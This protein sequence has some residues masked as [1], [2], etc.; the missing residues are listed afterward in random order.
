MRAST[1][2]KRSR[3]SHNLA[4]RLHSH[5]SQAITDLYDLYSE[6]LYVLVKTIAK[7]STVVNSLVQES[8]FRAW[9]RA[10]QLEEP[11]PPLGLWLMEI[12]RECALDYQKL[13]RARQLIATVSP[14]AN[15]PATAIGRESGAL[16][17]TRIEEG[18]A[19]LS[20]DQK[21]V[22]GLWF[23]RGLSDEA[24]ADRLQEPI[25][26]VKRL[27]KAGRNRLAQKLDLADF[28]SK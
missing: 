28:A 23:Y 3:Q 7:N 25:D 21:R 22:T 4:Q 8:F 17:N 1:A 27:R 19:S 18:F 9:N 16:E 5:E 10:A 13:S 24:I 11:F 15:F 6:L 14:T 20:E 26:K 2:S 12:A